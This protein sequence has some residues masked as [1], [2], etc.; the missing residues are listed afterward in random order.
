MNSKKHLRRSHS[1][2]RKT[3][4]LIIAGFVLAIVLLKSGKAVVSYTSS[5]KYCV[6]CHIHPVADQAWKL[7]THY[8][9]ASGNIVHCSECHLPPEGHGYIFAKAKHGFKDIYGY[10]FKDS[11]KINWQEKKLLEN[12]KGY[13]YEQS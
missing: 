10:L 3:F 9:N 11:A 8:N 7:S 1:A 4:W 2:G 5:D 13:V 12:A 6:S